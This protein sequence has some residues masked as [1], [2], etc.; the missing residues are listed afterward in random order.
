MSNQV[1][2][3]ET[4]SGLTK[5][6]MEVFDK[7]MSSGD[8]LDRMQL[9]TSASDCVKEGKFPANHYA[10]IRD[11]NM[12]DV[13]EEVYVAVLAMRPTAKAIGEQVI[14]SFDPESELFQDLVSK[15]EEFP[16]G[17]IYGPEFLLWV[18]GANKFCTFMCGSKTARRAAPALAAQLGK[19]ATLSS[20]LIK[21]SKHKWVGPQFFECSTVFE[22]PSEEE[23]EKQR[24][25]FLN[26]SD[27]K[28]EAVEEADTGRER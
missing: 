23:I 16:T 7:L 11:N 13:G 24:Q 28:V 19:T 6:G 8:Y 20:Q 3:P 27:S 17:Y 26:E 1:A 21:G 18:D 25:K 2:V 15:A 5:H 4:Q 22:I 12:T 9:M 14:Q 10:L